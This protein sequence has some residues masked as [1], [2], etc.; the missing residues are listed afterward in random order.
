MARDLFAELGIDVRGSEG[1]DTKLSPED[2]IKKVAEETGYSSDFLLG[3]A[4]LETRGGAATIKGDGVDTHNLFNIKD[5]S[6]DGTG[7]RAT[8]KA[9]GSNHRYR[10]YTDYE[11]S[12]RDLVRLLDR[13]YPD[14]RV[15]ETPQEFAQALKAGGYATDPAYVNKLTRTIGSAQGGSNLSG[16]ASQ[17]AP[18]TAGRDVFAQLG[19][20]RNRPAGGRDL[21]AEAGIDP[22]APWDG[23]GR[24]LFAEAG[25]DP[26][27]PMPGTALQKAGDYAG[28]VS[29]GIDTN[30]LG[31]QGGIGKFLQ[32]PAAN[33]LAAVA[34][35]VALAD[36]GITWLAN[37]LEGMDAK[38]NPDIQ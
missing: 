25:I 36:R 7:I 10:Q 4:K 3:L 19:I 15:A 23:G 18:G 32:A 9:E 28:A 13:K 37:K 34:G 22:K 20:D 29:S 17:Q 33:S 1:G 38:T 31:I 16:G 2:A 12:A 26:K 5:F 24:D 8:D 21:F 14:A 30:V 6:K 11:E 27:S 35:G